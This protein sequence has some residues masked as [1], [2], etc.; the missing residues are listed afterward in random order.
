MAE[1]V[2]EGMARDSGLEAQFSSA[3]TSSEELG[4]PI[5]W[6]AVRVLQAHGYRTSGHRAH[7][8]TPDEIRQADL[9]IGLEQLHINRMLRLVPDA[10][11]LA[12]MTDFDDE[13]EPGSGIEDPWY[14][15]QSGFDQTLAAIERAMPGLLDWIG[16]WTDD[17]AKLTMPDQRQAPGSNHDLP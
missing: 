2:A 10:D 5:D 8:I 1:R 17:T 3:G 11:N 14:G 6:R 12:L 7:Q 4:N 9:V 15:P 13:A 16:D